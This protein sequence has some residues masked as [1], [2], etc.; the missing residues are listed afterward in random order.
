MAQQDSTSSK[1]KKKAGFLGA[2]IA[3]FGQETGWAFGALGMYYFNTDSVTESKRPSSVRAIA[4]YTQKKQFFALL[5]FQI[6][7]KNRGEH[8]P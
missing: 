7:L 3:Y 8:Q 6:W 5:P 4:V 2:P 1:D